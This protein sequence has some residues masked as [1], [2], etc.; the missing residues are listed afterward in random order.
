NPCAPAQYIVLVTDGLPTKDL[1]G[2]NWPPLGSAAAAGYGVT[3]NAVSNPTLTINAD[4][5]FS[6]ND[7]AVLDTIAQIQAAEAAGIKTY[8]IGLGAGVDPANN[9]YAADTLTWMA[10]AGGTGNY[11]AANSPTALSADMQVILAKI[12]NAVRSSASATVNTTALNSTSM[13]FQPS[14]DTSDVNQD[15]TGDIKAYPIDAGSGNIETGMLAWSAQAQLD[16][17]ASGNGWS[18]RIIATWDPAASKAIPFE[19][20][21]GTPAT[22]IAISTDLGRALENNT[23]DANGQDALDY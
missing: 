2:N 1:S 3:P 13:A 16:A 6:T 21:S 19:W 7:Q 15:W 5:S 12:L 9:P 14:F 23:A 8:V 4:G 22:G 18:N 10:E 17:Q 11:F 20:S